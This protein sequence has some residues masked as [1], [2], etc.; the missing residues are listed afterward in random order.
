MT[1]RSRPFM[2]SVRLDGRR[3]VV[4]GG[5]DAATAKVET[6]IDTGAAVVVIAA[7]PSARLL[8]LAD[9]GRLMVERRSVR[10]RDLRGTALVIVSD[11][12]PKPG[13][14]ARWGRRAG[15][16]VNV[17]DTPALCDVT[18]PASI[19]IGP[20]TVAISTNGA[21]PAGA[22]FLREQITAALP[23]RLGELLDRAADA[24]D[25]LRTEGRYRYDYA[26]WRDDL[27][28][29]GLRELSLDG[30]ADLQV[31]AE[32]FVEVFEQPR[33]P[34]GGSVAL[35]GAGPG[36]ADLITLRGA[37][38][39][40]E[41]EVVLYDGLAD[42]ALLA[43]APLAAQ[44]IPVEKRKGRGPRQESINE[45]II[46]HGLA[47]RRVVRLKGGDP[48]VFGRGAEEVAAAEA[49]GL[50]VEVV[51]GLSASLAGPA[52]AG[53]TVTDRHLASG[54]TIISGHRA[55]SDDYDWEAI[56]RS[57]ST[58]IVLMAASTAATVADRLL[59]EV[60][61]NHPV[62]FVHNAG[63]TNQKVAYSTISDVVR[64][65]CP[66]PSPTVMVVGPTAV[67][68]EPGRG[69][70]VDRHVDVAHAE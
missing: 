38:L 3:V 39:L 56:G 63:R 7:E 37:R 44:R 28:E 57:A 21:T 67:R 35:V 25:E 33:R 15:A 49:V 69:D 18:V 60:G 31:L 14:I 41:A 29:P 53:I 36:G 16:M 24:R 27:L 32:H 62:A 55:G 8:D 48:F 45:L 52:L 5:D 26:R 34:T 12:V 19:D 50:P 30:T 17:V 65:G 58:L 54:A 40:A 68:G 13:R 59:A 43:L 9:R 46:E 64:D 70:E 23:E 4:V 1:D 66:F 51:P 47:G 61:P 2:V 20:A 6:L 11:S 10:R 22:R 42:P